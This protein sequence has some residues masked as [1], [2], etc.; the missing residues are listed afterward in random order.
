MNDMKKENLV[1]N[2][3][4]SNISKNT[5]KQKD[6]KE[7]T[8][9]LMDDLFPKF[10]KFEDIMNTKLW[11]YKNKKML[12]YHNDSKENNNT[13]ILLI[14]H[15]LIFIPILGALTYKLRTFNEDMLGLV[16]LSMLFYFNFG[17]VIYLYSDKVKKM[18]SMKYLDIDENKL[19]MKKNIELDNSLT[20]DSLKKILESKNQ[21]INNLKNGYIDELDNLDYENL[22]EMQLMLENDLKQINLAKVK[23]NV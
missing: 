1:F 12:I 3:L 18:K 6:N 2:D 13:T 9:L 4:I 15:L 11:G 22:K 10:N 7:K 23:S 14:V 8:Y 16:F 17:R 20:K 5:Q 21:Y 19:L